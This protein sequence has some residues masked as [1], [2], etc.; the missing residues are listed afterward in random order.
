MIF[1]WEIAVKCT[2]LGTFSIL[3][4]EKCHGE[5]ATCSQEQL[6]LC[7]IFH[8]ELTAQEE[9]QCVIKYSKTKMYL[10]NMEKTLE[11]Y[12]LLMFDLEVVLW[13]ILYS[14]AAKR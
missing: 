11:N 10:P 3:A 9:Q 12:S 4:I 8:V 2:L 7:P 13:H 14:S 6:Q 1:S 5:T